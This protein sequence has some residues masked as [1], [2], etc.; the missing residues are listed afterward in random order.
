[1]AYAQRL[2]TRLRDGLAAL[3]RAPGVGLRH[4]GPVQMPLLLFNDDPDF[5]KGVA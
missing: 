2:G 3:A 5:A 1:L 4:S